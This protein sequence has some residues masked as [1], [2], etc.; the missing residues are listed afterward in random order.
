M[1]RINFINHQNIYF[2][3]L[4]LIR[5]FWKISRHEPHRFLE[6]SF[7]WESFP[8]IGPC[9]RIKWFV[10]GLLR[11]SMS[12]PYWILEATLPVHVLRG[13]WANFLNT[14]QQSQHGNK[15]FR[16]PGRRGRWLSSAELITLV[17]V[18][19]WLKKSSKEIL[20]R[21]GICMRF[22]YCSLSNWLEISITWQSSET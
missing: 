16:N 8:V 2:I 9:H 20:S 14:K 10:S 13:W 22:W 12:S 15:E 19:R 21:E 1:F 5:N 3:K 17:L 7:F 4:E 18:L 6:N 11:A